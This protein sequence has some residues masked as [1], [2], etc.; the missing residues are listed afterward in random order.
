MKSGIVKL[1]LMIGCTA[2]VAGGLGYWLGRD[3][4]GAGRSGEGSGGL[5]GKVD[6]GDGGIVVVDGEKAGEGDEADAGSG[7]KSSSGGGD[8]SGAFAS[9]EVKES[10]GEILDQAGPLDRWKEMMV[11][12]ESLGDSESVEAAI[13]ELDEMPQ[14][15][16]SYVA[17]FF[18]YS[19]LGDGD[20]ETALARLAEGGTNSMGGMAA[21]SIISSWAGRDPEAAAAYL[22]TQVDENGEFRDQERRQVRSVANEWARSDPEAAMEWVMGLDEGARKG[23][24]G[25]VLSQWASQDARS[26]SLYV[27][28]VDLGAERTGMV[29]AVAAQWGRQD[30]QAAMV[31]AQGLEGDERAGAM[32]SVLGAWAA[33]DVEGA[34][35]QLAGM[36]AGKERD[37][38]F[39]RV[40]GQW[41]QQDVESAANW[42]V[43]QEVGE[44]ASKGAMRNVMRTWAGRNEFDA[45]EWLA[46]RP[47]GPATDGA[48]MGLT[49]RV[50]GKDP[51]SAAYWALA[52][53]DEGDRASQ[54]GR[55]VDQWVRKDRAAA[56]AW[57]SGNP[58]VPDAVR[59]KL[60]R[61]AAP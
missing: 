41:V 40:A 52:I 14:D 51:E 25:A 28:N 39:G 20:P 43:E 8:V 6:R 30:S 55:V 31:W 60:Q 13:Q 44:T 16:D 15:I 37:L 21:E 58:D 59:A 19:Q 11:F 2:V 27:E 26:A 49:D 61:D 7:E 42:V 54:V 9:V 23:S 35:E 34:A 3:A 47:P 18:L 29:A 1:F 38:A 36:E 24:A 4:A 32:A 53:S 50:V 45:A 46:D 22:L 57:V 10:V 33:Q 12:A 17:R 56:T 5:V 48:I